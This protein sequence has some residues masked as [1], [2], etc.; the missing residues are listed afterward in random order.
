MSNR[1]TPGLVTIT[2]RAFSPREIVELAAK[3]KLV[4]LEW[5]GDVHVP[6]GE[7]ARAAEVRK[8]TADMGLRTVAYGSYVRLGEE[9]ARGQLTAAVQTARAL[10]APAIRVWAGKRGSAAADADYRKRVVADA[11]RL[12]ELAAAEQIV[13]CYEYHDGTLTDTDASAHELL[14]A[15]QHPWIKTLWQPPHDLD[16]DGRCESLRGVLPWLQ[17]VHVFHWPRRGE[18][19]A[20]S[21]GAAGWPRYIQTL[22]EHS[23]E[24]PLLLEFVRGDDP[25]QLLAD[26]RTLHEWI[27]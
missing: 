26:A 7:L 20:L 24:C 27:A 12:A 2:F 16:I 18:R 3:A 17:H 13:V 21:E 15:T 1:F 4:G 25:Q 5:G 19:A 11:L 23:R 6:V 10:G 9:G 8:M 22:R 14:A